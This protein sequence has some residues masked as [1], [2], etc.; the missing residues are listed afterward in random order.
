M[1]IIAGNYEKLRKPFSHSFLRQ[2]H[3]MIFTEM[4]SLVIRTDLIMI[5]IQTCHQENR[6]RRVIKHKIHVSRIA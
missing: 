2:G 1:D 3:N 4:R 5:T 6:K